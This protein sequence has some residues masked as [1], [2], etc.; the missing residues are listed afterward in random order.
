MP[1]L[2]LGLFGGR[3]CFYFADLLD[4]RRGWV[5]VC[6]VMR[7]GVTEPSFRSLIPGGELLKRLTSLYVLVRR[8]ISL[9]STDVQRKASG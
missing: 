7:P 4:H 6:S 5:A 3:H 8:Q 9:F 2:L 1:A